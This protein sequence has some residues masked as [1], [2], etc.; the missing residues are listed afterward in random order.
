[1]A[2]L[3]TTHNVSGPRRSAFVKMSM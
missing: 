1:L 3:A 2:S